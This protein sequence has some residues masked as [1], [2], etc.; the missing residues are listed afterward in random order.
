MTRRSSSITIRD[1]AREAGVSVATVSRYINHNA[2]VSSEVA[3]R[4]NKVMTGLRYTPHA[5]ARHLATRKTR[6]IGLILNSMNYDF[7]APLLSG[8]EEIV[9][10][11]EHN[12][13]VATYRSDTRQSFPPP[14]GPHNTDGVVVFADTLDDAHLTQWYQLDFPVV[15]VHRTPPDALPI[16][17]VTIENK[18]A[19]QSMINHL[20]EVHGRRRI[21]FMR[22][23][24]HQEDSRWR[25]LGYRAAL[26]AHAIDYDERLVLNGGFDRDIA[27]EAMSAFISTNHVQFDAVFSGDDDSAVGTLRALQEARLSVPDQVSVVGFDDQHFSSFINPPLTTIQ[28]P[29]EEVGRTA[30]RQL[31]QVLKGEQTDLI[32]LLP[33][34]IVIRVSC[35]CAQTLSE[36]KEVVSPKNVIHV[37]S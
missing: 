11:N 35:G 27:Y 16:P 1:V 29:T 15:L 6:A 23:P 10:E 19:T 13:L 4:I 30:G 14:I 20:I 25:E 3:V 31:F 12:L 37:V 2:P 32:T 34:R 8:L 21:V 18:T 36:K 17:C 22:G 26:E 9:A 28:A 7:F 33:T 5:V 24:E